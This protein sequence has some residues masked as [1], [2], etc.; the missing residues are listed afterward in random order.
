MSAVRPE[1]AAA[2]LAREEL[3]MGL[4]DRCSDILAAIEDDAGVPVGVL[5]LPEGF[6]GVMKRT[7]G[8]AFIFVNGTEAVVRQRFT[9]AHEYGH[10]KLE[11][12]TVFDRTVDMF[13]RD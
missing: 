2:R 4:A 7:R 12:G 11:H 8:R 1:V 9:L 10:Y 3:G 5:A 13:G 6:A